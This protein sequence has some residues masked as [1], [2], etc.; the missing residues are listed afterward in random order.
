[1]RY[2]TSDPRLVK[3]AFLK[4]F[5]LTPIVGVAEGHNAVATKTMRQEA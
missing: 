5:A 4:R 2:D 1:L 3:K